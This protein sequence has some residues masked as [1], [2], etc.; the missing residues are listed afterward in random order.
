MQLTA[1]RFHP[2]PSPLSLPPRRWATFREVFALRT[3]RD[4][5]VHARTPI[6]SVDIFHL[7]LHP[8]PFELPSSV[9]RKLGEQNMPPYIPPEI[10][11]AIISDV[12]LEDDNVRLRSHTLAMC[13]LVCRA[14]LPRSRDKLFEDIRI[15]G[16]RTYDLLVER[17]LHSEI[18]SPFLASV[19]TLYLET[20]PGPYQS[21]K[22]AR[23][24]FVEF[25]GKLPGLRTLFVDGMDFTHQ[26]PSVKWPLLL[27]QFRTITT[28]TFLNCEFAS[29]HDVRRLLTALPLLSTLDIQQLTWPMVSHELHLQTMAMARPR[30]YWPEL[31]ELRIR[32]LPPQCAAV[33]L[34]WITAALHGSP[35]RVLDCR[36]S[37]LPSAGSL[38]ESVDAFMG[39]VG[40]SITD[41]HVNMTDNLPLSGFIALKCLSCNLGYY[42]GNWEDLASVLQ[43][44]LPNMIQSITFNDVYTDRL[45]SRGHN[46]A[47]FLRFD[48]DTLE[49]IDR[50]L[51]C[52]RFGDLREVVLRVW[53]DDEE[54]KE[55]LCAHARRC[56][57]KLHKRKILLL[58]INWG[59]QCLDVE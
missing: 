55:L 6:L 52:E 47:A 12:A 24:F 20:L 27:S 45:Q 7:S 9:S 19:N 5:P 38:R 54:N 40:P 30:T 28:L 57:P 26:R 35:V 53:P 10:T 50:I 14:W 37:D 49:E 31:R 17:V 42:K 11:D 43:G 2:H 23:L 25:A 56:L 36:F 41:L 15:R 18:M 29:F 48:H 8:A 1:F 4:T 58:Y 21:S 32:Y 39:R 33:F 13:A 44:V 16:E 46:D 34:R 3:E 22:A 59:L 51:S